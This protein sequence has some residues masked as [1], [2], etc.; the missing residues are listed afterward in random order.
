MQV[1][2]LLGCDEWQVGLEES[3]GHEKRLVVAGSGF[4][5]THGFS[6]DDAIAVGFVGN[7]GTFPGRASGWLAL[8]ILRAGQRLI[9]SQR[10]AFGP[11]LEVWNVPGSS[12]FAVAMAHM[13][14]LAHGLG[15]IAMPVEILGHG[16]RF[17]TGS[18]E[19]CAQI[20]DAQRLW[21]QTGHQGIARRRADRLVAIG[22]IKPYTAG[23][24]GVDVRGFGVAV[25]IT[26]E[27]RL[28][29]IDADEK[30]VWLGGRSGKWQRGGK[31]NGE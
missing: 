7:I 16:D 18:P 23:R 27:G 14:D 1:P 30:N 20:I 19:I 9:G 15:A 31:Q 3:N 28:Q 21:A 12:V 11:W 26:A 17:R 29:V 2:V 5:A 4:Q 6:R 8:G 25:A 10:V 22:A 13:H 24:D